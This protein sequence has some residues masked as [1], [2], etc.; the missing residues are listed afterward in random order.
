MTGEPWSIFDPRECQLGEGPHYD[1][2]TGRVW[3]VD[4][5]GRRVLWRSFDEPDNI[6]EIATPAHVGAAVPRRNGGMV[7][8]VPSG[9]I[10]I[11]EAGI[12]HELARYPVVRE[13][14]RSN[15][16]KADP[17][18][19]LWL[20]TMSYDEGTGEGALYR[21]DP[22]SEAPVTV[23]PHVTVS[24]GLGWSRDGSTMYYIDS[25]TG[26]VDAYEF[27]TAA[28]A[29]GER[30]TFATI[31]EGVPDGMC[32]DAQG[33]VWVA[34]WNGS[35]VQRH[36]PDGSLDRV[37]RLP[38]PKVT[39]CAFAG[40]ELSTLIVTTVGQTYAFEIE[41]VTGLPADRFAG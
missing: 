1:E 7:A 5:L 21:L 28:G 8:C 20:G 24:N 31:E 35:R 6:G 39:S 10:G 37:L 3:W 30:R 12:W 11:D 14:V 2:R 27:D 19:R 17:Q 13:S 4:I 41:D 23:L 29:L 32:V 15:D 16:A 38:V 26:R 36:R 9:A 40:P 22:G 34:V 18:G 25:P 33:G